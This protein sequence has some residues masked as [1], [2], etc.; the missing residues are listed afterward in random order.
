[1]HRWNKCCVI[2]GIY[3]FIS[4]I[5]SS[6][7]LR[8]TSQGPLPGSTKNEITEGSFL[9]VRTHFTIKHKEK[10]SPTDC[11]HAVSA[12]LPAVL[13]P[14]HSSPFLQLCTYYMGER[15]ISRPGVL[16]HLVGVATLNLP[17]PGSSVSIGKRAWAACCMDILGMTETLLVKGL[18]F[19]SS[20]VC[21]L[22]CILFWVY[23]GC[24]IV[25][26]KSRFLT[27]SLT[28]AIHHRATFN[29]F[30]YNNTKHWSLLASYFNGR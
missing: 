18:V 13:H 10:K 4:F 24:V 2:F 7:K 16:L 30:T 21:I 15:R 26:K 20:A 5:H 28:V 27:E 25:C 29:T 11:Q 14:A 1:M 12:Q 9:I 19:S 3:L 17:A 22:K 23:S 8:K 6:T